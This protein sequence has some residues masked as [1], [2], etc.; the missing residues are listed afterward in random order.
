MK[1]FTD[2]EAERRVLSGMMNSETACIEAVDKIRDTQFTDRLNRQV[3]ILLSDLYIRGTRPTYIELIKEGTT[4]GLI[5]KTRDVGII[6]NI[7]ESYIDDKNITYCPSNEAPDYANK[8]A[9]WALRQ[10]CSRIHLL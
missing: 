5:E 10:S 8:L 3:F 6:Q 4:L 1:N 7:A 2:Q 9:S